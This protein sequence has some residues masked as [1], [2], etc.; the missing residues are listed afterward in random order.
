MAGMKLALL[1]PV[2]ALPV[3]LPAAPAP[4]AAEA[5]PL[6]DV[7][8]LEGPFRD[9]QQR[10]LAY[11]LSLDPD[12]LLH[13]FRL[14]AGLPTTA[15]P[16]GGWEA[17]QV[18][19]RGHSLGHYLTACALMHEATGDE[20]LEGPRAR[21]RGRA[22]EGAAGPALARD[23]PGLSLRLPRGVL[24]PGRGPQ[25][26]VGALLHAA[27]DHG[28]PPRRPPCDRRPR[29]ARGGEGHGHVGGCP[30]EAPDGRAVAERCWRPSSAG[31][32]TC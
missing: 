21:D 13:T 2:L 25:G 23:A 10:D 19:L 3:A 12:R 26:R 9:A 30:G 11:L 20:R 5:F 22:A 24:R 29:G 6:R 18:E 7:R 32:R 4:P 17:P 14:N 16:Y 28:R 1:L 15:K 27:Q 8:I 31:W